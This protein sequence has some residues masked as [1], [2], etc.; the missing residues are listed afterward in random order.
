MVDLNPT[1]SIIRQNVNCSSTLVKRQRLPEW[2]KNQDPVIC[3]LQKIQFKYKGTHRLKVKGWKS[4]AMLILI[5]K[6]TCNDYINTRQSRFLS[7]K[8]YYEQKVS[9][10]NNK[11]ANSLEDKLFMHVIKSQ[12]TWSKTG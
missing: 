10:Y 5:L 9:F 11:V 4:Y 12:I 7:K 8:H 1:I 6:K 2:I 3:C